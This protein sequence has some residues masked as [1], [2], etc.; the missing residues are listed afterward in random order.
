MADK[1]LPIGSKAV[2]TDTVCGGEK[3]EVVV[4]RHGWDHQGV[5]TQIKLDTGEETR[6]HRSTLRTL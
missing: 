2:W 6:V 4:T 5:Y 1:K 3:R